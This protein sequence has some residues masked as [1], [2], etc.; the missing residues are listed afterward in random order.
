VAL[1]K[2]GPIPVDK[3]PLKIVIPSFIISELR[4][5]LSNGFSCCSCR[6]YLSTW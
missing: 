4:D 2:T 6:L 5:G 3:L 1:A